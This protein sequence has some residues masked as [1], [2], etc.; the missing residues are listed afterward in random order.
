MLQSGIKASMAVRIYGDDIKALR[1]HAG[2][3][4]DAIAGVEGISDLKIEQQVLVPQLDV[5]LKP[6]AAT[7][8]W[9]C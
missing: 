6:A 4:R 2:R 9:P 3:V 8:N 5:R 7:A 1:R